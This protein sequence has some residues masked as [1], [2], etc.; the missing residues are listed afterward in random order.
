MA[1]IVY[2]RALC[3][4][5]RGTLARWCLALWL[6]LSSVCVAHCQQYDARWT[7]GYA[8]GAG[9]AFGGNKT[10]FDQ[11][12]ATFSVAET[13]F[14]YQEA[15]VAT[16]TDAQDSIF[17]YT[18]GWR[19]N[20]AAHLPM[21]NGDGLNP[22]TAVATDGG[23]RAPY[24][25]LIVPWPAHPDSFLLFHNVPD[26][27]WPVS[28][29]L[30]SS[31]LYYSVIVQ[32]LDGDTL[33]GISSKNNVLLMEPVLVGGLGVVK[34]ANG[35]DWWLLSHGMMNDEF[36]LFLLSPSG[37]DG[38]FYQAIG[39]VME[40]SAPG[41][42]FSMKG[43]RL[44]YG[45]FV[46]G[47]DI[48]DFDRCT[49]ILSNRRNVNFTEQATFRVGQFS[50]DGS[51]IYVPAGIYIYQLQLEPDGD[52]AA[53]DT[54]AFYDGFYDDNP[55]FATYFVYPMLAR[56][57]RIYISTGNTTRYMHVINEPDLAGD[58]CDGETPAA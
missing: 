47:L 11:S 40:G 35:R 25:Q 4:S 12:G 42:I 10:L 56:D 13:H 50:P 3:T 9:P 22:T 1:T 34:H 2:A 53:I 37:I 6:A 36:V 8:E 31:K 21:L 20:N 54:V 51:K 18:N 57:G 16:I 58:A 55:V 49:G 44:A 26:A 27:F 7:G 33:A 14:L 39:A 29:N 43:D 32:G 5:E 52:V 48:Y 38:P 19:F 24:S 41:A 23:A 28:N 30:Y 45:Q 46:S 15:G 17:A